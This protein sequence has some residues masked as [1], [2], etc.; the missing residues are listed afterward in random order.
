MRRIHI[1]FVPALALGVALALSACGGDDSP[2]QVI[3]VPTD[4]TASTTSEGS[5]SKADFI[6]QADPICE[7][8]NSAIQAFADAGQGLTEADQIAQLRAGVISDLNGLG[9]PAEDKETLD[10]FL[11]AMD[12][13]V[14]AGQKI[15]LAN[16]RGT[17]TAEFESE[18]ATAKD[19]AST[20]ASTYG[21]QSCG[22]DVTSSSSSSS[23]GSTGTSTA[24]AT[25]APVTPAPAPSDGGTGDTGGDTGSGG[26]GV[27]PGGGGVSP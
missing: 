18:L 17:D 10:A 9:L 14:S 21:F 4:T 13:E 7:Q 25:S 1:T 23:T 11:A 3:T 6:A 22:S 24:P 12:Q 27:S 26:G 2:E 19:S 8:A 16:D 20:A 15:A 5:L